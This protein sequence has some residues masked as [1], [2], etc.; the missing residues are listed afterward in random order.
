MA[1][2]VLLVIPAFREFHR[3]P[4]YLQELVAVLSSAKFT[5]EILIVDDGS[6]LEDQQRLL[7][8]LTLGA[9]GAC[10][11]LEPILLSSNHGKGHAII[12]GWSL[13][14]DANWLGFVDADGAIPAYEVLRVLDMTTLSGSTNPPCL[15][16]SRIRILG[17]KINRTLRRHLLGRIFATLASK[18]ID[19]PVYDTQCG[20]KVMPYLY[21]R[22]IA[23][24]LQEARFCF[25]IE[26]LLAARHVGATVVEIPIDWHDVPG[27]QLHTIRD[28][29]SMLSRLPAI[30]NRAKNW[31]PIV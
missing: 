12:H 31:P 16:A 25:D 11:V 20:F 15:W 7:S 27:G 3:L 28:G 30:R 2:D 18:F 13:N 14:K 21:Y 19:L 26:L 10:H 9:F 1:A 8:A 17:K 24:L 6:P 4:P 23:P 29:I 5:T 22:K